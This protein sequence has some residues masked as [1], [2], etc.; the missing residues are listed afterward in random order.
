MH[1]HPSS[2]PLTRPLDIVV[3]EVAFCQIDAG[4]ELFLKLLLHRLPRATFDFHFL[5]SGDLDEEVES[6]N[7]AKSSHWLGWR[8]GGSPIQKT[9]QCDN[10]RNV[11]EARGAWHVATSIDEFFAM[12]ISMLLQK[13]EKIKLS[14]RQEAP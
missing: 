12:R 14:V 9:Q 2:W 3:V 5:V 11:E 8:R 6:F 1:E 10:R 4:H 7:G 13:S